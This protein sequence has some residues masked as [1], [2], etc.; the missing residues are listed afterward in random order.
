MTSPV[1]ASRAA[2]SVALRVLQAVLTDL[3]RDGIVSL[4]AV[5]RAI[6]LIERGTIELDKA[7]MAARQRCAQ[8]PA[9]RRSGLR[10]NPVNRLLVKPFESLFFTTPSGFDRK[11]LPAYFTAAR[12]LIGP[13]FAIY[14]HEC[15]AILQSLFSQH[16]SRLDWDT[17][18]ADPRTVSLMRRM[19]G[20]MAQG[21]R[22]RQGLANW[23][24]L[25]LTPAADGTLPT[26]KQVSVIRQLILS[27]VDDL[28]AAAAE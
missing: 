23:R 22:G 2:V 12:S 25:M 11:F 4:D 8:A 14:D 21:L 26:E 10:S 15:K 6:D 20:S 27:F 28:P 24:G 13:S 7:Y 17:V 3:G 19:I 9:G 5:D 16:G 1:N 18:Y